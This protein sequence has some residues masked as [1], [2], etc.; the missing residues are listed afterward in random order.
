MV[1]SPV[2]F[3]LERQAARWALAL[4]LLSAGSNIP[5]R[6]AIIAITTSNSISVK[7]CLPGLIAALPAEELR[8]LFRSDQIAL[9]GCKAD[10][11]CN[12]SFDGRRGACAPRRESSTTLL[13]SHAVELTART[14][15]I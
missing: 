9:I 6:M 15:R 3:R 8:H 11:N 10:C 7:A 2:C 5:A 1:A 14:G 13:T 12:F 4:A